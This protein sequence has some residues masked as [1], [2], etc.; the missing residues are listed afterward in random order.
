MGQEW[1]RV[2]ALTQREDRTYTWYVC[3]GPAFPNMFLCSELLETRL[4]GALTA[5][6]ELDGFLRWS[7]TAWNPQ[8]RRSLQWHQFPA[9]DSCL[10]YPGADGRPL[11]SLRYQQLRRAVGDYTLV[12][13]LRGRLGE[14]ARPVLS[15][16]WE[17]LFKTDDP[18]RLAACDSGS[19]E[20][21]NLDFSAF[22]EFKRRLL[23][24]L[25]GG[26]CPEAGGKTR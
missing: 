17:R 21:F 20:L 2:R 22:Q 12:S 8:P 11:L 7:Y 25:E 23:E 26:A 10:V 1:E 13:L 14:A 19:R 3:C 5:F 4:A 9:G 24:V 15:A 16:C 18:R 6:L